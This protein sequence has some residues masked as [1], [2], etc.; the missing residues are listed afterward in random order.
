VHIAIIIA[1]LEQSDLMKFS[2]S[3]G[4]L[5]QTAAATERI[6]ALQTSTTVVPLLQ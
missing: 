6:S 3:S 4:S 5:A 2:F 1:S